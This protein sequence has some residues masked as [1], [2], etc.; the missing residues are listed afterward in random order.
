[1][2]AICAICVGVL[3]SGLTACREPTQSKRAAATQI[4]TSSEIRSKHRSARAGTPVGNPDELA[5]VREAPDRRGGAVGM[6]LLLL[7]SV[8]ARLSNLTSGTPQAWEGLTAM[9]YERSS[10]QPPPQG[11]R[12]YFKDDDQEGVLR[13]SNGRLTAHKPTSTWIC[14]AGRKTRGLDACTG[15]TSTKRCV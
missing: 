10:S 7:T 13:Y 2:R 15:R 8:P 11:E 9:V 3:A 14:V 12:N 5:G 1:M 6:Q 4:P